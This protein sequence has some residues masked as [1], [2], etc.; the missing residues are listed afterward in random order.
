MS[1]F[2]VPRIKRGSGPSAK[3]KDW[4]VRKRAWPFLIKDFQSRCAY[5]MRHVTYCGE[6]DME[7]DHFNPTLKQS[8]RHCYRNLMLA[9]ALCN[10]NKNATW[11]TPAELRRGI[12]LIDP[13]KESDYGSQI[14]ENSSTHELIG[15][16]PAGR[17][18]I[19]ILDLNNP[20]FVFERRHR[21]SIE[22]LRRGAPA[23]LSGTFDELECA[24]QMVREMAE[25]FIPPI[26]PPPPTAEHPVR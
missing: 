24:M 5:S 23:I 25:I 22:K 3:L 9:T 18:Q 7:I 16:T 15:T 2:S 13:T 6:S 20:S 4:N 26:P 21:S 19:D 12:H 17:Y 1:D 11:P 8:A 10:N 14:F